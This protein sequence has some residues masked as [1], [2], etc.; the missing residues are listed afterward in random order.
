MQR[1]RREATKGYTA[2]TTSIPTINPIISKSTHIVLL[3]T[4]IVPVAAFDIQNHVF[5]GTKVSTARTLL[6]GEELPQE[7]EKSTYP[8][9][10]NKKDK[11]HVSGFHLLALFRATQ[12]FG[13]QFIPEFLDMYVRQ[14]RYFPH[15]ERVHFRST[16]LISNSRAEF[17]QT[18]EIHLPEAVFRVELCQLPVLA[19]HKD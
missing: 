15:M 5:A 9:Q 16:N 4:A 17:P 1:Y 13:I 11:Q 14:W 7:D 18:V 2:Q 3:V 12:Y 8:Q 6:V 19:G 10:T